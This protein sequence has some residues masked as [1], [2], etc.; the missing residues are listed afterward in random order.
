MCQRL[1]IASRSALPSVR[2]SRKA[3]HL[4]VGPLANESVRQ[5]FSVEAKHLAE[6][7]G[8][9]ECGC[10]FP[11]AND[12]RPKQAVPPEDAETVKTLA[13]YL[14]SLPKRKHAVEL[15]L[16]NAGMEAEP[17]TT[18]RDVSIS[19]LLVPGFRFR[20]REGLRVRLRSAAV[21]A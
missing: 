12:E 8:H 4:A 16:S 10:G 21:S 3:P 13:A 7:R 9:V 17:P 14:R 18:W 1:Y 5:F 19:D 6:A 2:A 20:R 11:E 15:V